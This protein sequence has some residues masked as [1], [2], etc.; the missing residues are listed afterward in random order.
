VRYLSELAALISIKVYEFSPERAL[1]KALTTDVRIKATIITSAD[2]EKLNGTEFHVD[3]D[4]MVLKSNKRKRKT[5]VTAEI[6]LERNIKYG[7]GLGFH[8]IVAEL[9]SLTDHL[10]VYITQTGINSE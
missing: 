3:L 4:F 9:S 10:V 8:I 1:K 7:A 5:G 6:E 2:P